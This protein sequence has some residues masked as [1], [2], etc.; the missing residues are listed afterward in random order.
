MA[1]QV[2][3]LR[4]F[5][6]VMINMDFFSGNRPKICVPIVE[7]GLPAIIKAVKRAKKLPID[8]LEWRM[9]CFF[10]DP[11]QVFADVVKETEGF[12]LLCTLRTEGE[13]GKSNVSDSQYEKILTYIIDSGICQ[14]I[15]IEF[16]NNR[17][18]TAR[19]IARAKA[20]EVLTVV[21]KHYFDCT[22]N[23]NMLLENFRQMHELGA[24]LPKQAAMP[25][26]IQDVMTLLAASIEAKERYGPIV[27]IS[28]GELGKISRVGGEYF[29]SAMTFAAMGKSSAPGQL[30]AE[31][32]RYILEDL[33]I[34]S[35][36]KG[37]L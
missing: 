5:Q 19:L 6:P 18:I 23:K 22:P 12:P 3:C 1:G 13:G 29:G 26:D 33:A 31:D 25:T 16:K 30:P 17:D 35:G 14:M 15:D 37:K 34:N 11:A 32:L 4:Q 20:K 36:G 8:M 2:G 9:D 27:A 7:S 28:M 21:S 24:D 10:D